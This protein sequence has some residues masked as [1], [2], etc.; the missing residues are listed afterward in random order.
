MHGKKVPQRDL[1][2][3]VETWKGLLASKCKECPWRSYVLPNEPKWPIWWWK[4]NLLCLVQ[5]I[6]S[7]RRIV[8]TRWRP[9][10]TKE[11]VCTPRSQRMLAKNRR[12]RT[13]IMTSQR[14]G[15]SDGFCMTALHT[16]AA[17][18]KC[19]FSFPFHLGLY[20]LFT[21]RFQPSRLMF[22][23][24]IQAQFC[25]QPSRLLFRSA[26]QAQFCVQ[27]PRLMFCSA[28]QAQFCVQPFWLMFRP[29]SFHYSPLGSIIVV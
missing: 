29:G 13:H 12:T 3:F 6:G 8:Q 22:R 15:K 7:C 16:A 11:A 25:V 27:P 21:M 10:R 4:W 17:M 20:S 2:K 5:S 24:A 1:P 19:R 18:S 9:E 23:S 28:I 26:I 14:K